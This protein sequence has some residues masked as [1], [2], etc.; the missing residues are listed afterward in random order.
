MLGANPKLQN[1]LQHVIYYSRYWKILDFGRWKIDKGKEETV[2]SLAFNK[3]FCVNMYPR[4][5]VS[6]FPEFS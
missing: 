1:C 3:A 6:P 4:V 2:S 5:S